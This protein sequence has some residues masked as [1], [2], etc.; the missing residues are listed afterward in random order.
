MGQL[1][2]RMGYGFRVHFRVKGP[3]SKVILLW[4]YV[5]KGLPLKGWGLAPGTPHTRRHP[6]QPSGHLRLQ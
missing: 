3:L 6:S 4:K 2:L 5:T 1:I